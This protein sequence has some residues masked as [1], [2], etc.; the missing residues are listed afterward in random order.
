L[1][2]KVLKTCCYKLGSLVVEY[3]TVYLITGQ[4]MLSARIVLI[5]TAV[6]ALYYYLFECFWTKKERL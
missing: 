3:L 5:V 2:S 4:I 6:T 1:K